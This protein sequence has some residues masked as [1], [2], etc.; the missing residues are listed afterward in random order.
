MEVDRGPMR[1]AL[2]CGSPGR[3]S[4][5][6]GAN[7][8]A[9]RAVQAVLSERGAKCVETADVAEVP[10]FRAEDVDNAPPIVRAMRII[11]ESVDA[12]VL[13]TPEFGGGAAGAAKNALDW[14]VGSGSL[15]ERPC[16]VMTAGTTGGANAIEQI[17]R[18]LTWQGAVVMATL[19][20]ATPRAARDEIGHFTDGGS[21]RAFRQLAEAVLAS[22]TMTELARRS[23]AAETVRALGIDPDRRSGR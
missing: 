13:A 2:F 6:P 17:A 22:R 7:L 15:Y 12:V 14:M 5:R 1:V 8:A 4:A 20:I 3:P 19:G 11:F 16:F 10:A 9:L 21:L 18:T 23:A